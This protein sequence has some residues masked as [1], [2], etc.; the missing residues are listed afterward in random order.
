MVGIAE[1]QFRCWKE[2]ERALHWKLLLPT[3][4]YPFGS[5]FIQ[6]PEANKLRKAADTSTATVWKV[7]FFV[8]I[9]KELYN[10]VRV[11]VHNNGIHFVGAMITYNVW[12]TISTEYL[13]PCTCKMYVF[14]ILFS[15]VLIKVMAVLAQPRG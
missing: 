9:M 12:Y 13:F 7:S 8:Y 11:F 6:Q 1:N 15:K 5:S 2:K 4:Y 10:F 14:Y 3:L